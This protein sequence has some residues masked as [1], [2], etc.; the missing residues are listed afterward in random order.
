[1]LP[2]HVI[3]QIGA[4]STGSIPAL[5]AHASLFSKFVLLVL[6]AL[7][8][9]SWAILWDRLRLYREVTAQD[10]SFLKA[11]RAA[12]DTADLRLIAR[13][14]PRSVLAATAAALVADTRVLPQMHK[15][16]GIR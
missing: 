12:A 2:A 8:V 3:L 1:M 15:L 14:H 10:A 5:I 6:L 13:Q 16:V 4:G 11:F 7:S 9:Y